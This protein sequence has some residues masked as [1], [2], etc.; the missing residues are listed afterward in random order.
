[1]WISYLEVLTAAGIQMAVLWV[2]VPCSWIEDIAMMMEAASTFETLIYFYKT[3][4]HYNTEDSHLN[5]FCWM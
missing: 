3:T 5:I 4:Q 1:V 2:V